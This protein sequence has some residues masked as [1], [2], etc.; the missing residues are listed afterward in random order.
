MQKTFLLRWFMWVGPHSLAILIAVVLLQVDLK[1]FFLFWFV[2]SHYQRASYYDAQRCHARS[3]QF[4]T[5]CKLTAILR[6][7]T[8]SEEEVGDIAVEILGRM[9]EKRR[10]ELTLDLETASSD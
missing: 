8:I 4:A 10:Q 6:K 5:D 9:P 2:E 1:W 3:N 7:L